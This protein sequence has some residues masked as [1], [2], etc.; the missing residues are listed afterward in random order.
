[1]FCSFF[2]KYFANSLRKLLWHKLNKEYFI[3]KDL[4]TLSQVFETE[5]KRFFNIFY[6]YAKINFTYI[7]LFH[8]LS[9]SLFPYIYS[10]K[11]E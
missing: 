8:F 9:L 6:V 1:M 4:K 2:D 3:S 7:S 11:N 5:L 10:I